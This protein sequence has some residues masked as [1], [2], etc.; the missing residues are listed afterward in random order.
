[1]YSGVT[2]STVCPNTAHNELAT[3]HHASSAPP[4]TLNQLT[5][6][7]PTL[8]KHQ[9]TCYTHQT[10]LQDTST[11]QP[12]NNL[13]YAPLASPNTTQHNTATHALHHAAPS[14]IQDTHK[15]YPGLVHG[16]APVQQLLCHR[17]MTFLACDPE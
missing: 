13:T 1:M 16:S 2:P 5:C 11:I 14:H 6:A 4:T 3:I 10:P 15:S 7:Q 8:T 17:S 12:R 9:P